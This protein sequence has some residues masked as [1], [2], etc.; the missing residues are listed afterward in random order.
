MPELDDLFDSLRADT[1]RARW[2]DAATVRAQGDRRIRW[3]WAAAVVVLGLLVG[4]LGVG[5][6]YAR[7]G[8]PSGPVLPAG[9]SPNRSAGV[10]VPSGVP[11][12]PRPAPASVPPG[13][14]SGPPITAA[15][16]L[17]QADIGPVGGP[18]SPRPPEVFSQ[19]YAPNPFHYCGMDGYPGNDQVAAALGTSLNGTGSYSTV[20]DSV[21]SFAPGGARATMAG[22]R[23]L[24]TGACRGHVT[25]MA[26]DV[27]GDE[28]LLLRGEDSETGAAGGRRIAY[29]VIV[30]RGDRVAW[31]TIVDFANRADFAGYARTLGTQAAGRLCAGTC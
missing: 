23:A 5:I 2:T 8:H 7:A 3:Q 28:S 15:M 17:T 13:A 1:D 9:P 14:V 11:V 22:V 12:P 19:L 20:G 30:R 24:L 4:A 29:Q 6:A 18:G 10:P 31:V 27:G 16:L 25:L 26:T 21:L